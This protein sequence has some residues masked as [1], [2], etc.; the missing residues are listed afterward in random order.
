MAFLLIAEFAVFE[1]VMHTESYMYL[2]N[3]SHNFT[4]GDVLQLPG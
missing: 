1:L 4:K 3:L 2:T